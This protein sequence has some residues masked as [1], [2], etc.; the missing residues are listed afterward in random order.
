MWTQSNALQTGQKFQQTT[1]WN[2]FLVFP[3]KGFGISCKLSLMEPICMK[4]QT[5][6]LGKNKKTII[7]LSSAEF[8]RTLQT[9]DVVVTVQTENTWATSQCSPRSNC[10][11]EHFHLG[12]HCLLI[13]SSRNRALWWFFVIVLSETYLADIQWNHHRPSLSTHD[14]WV[15]VQNRINIGYIFWTD[16]TGRPSDSSQRPFFIWQGIFYLSSKSIS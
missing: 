16:C 9:L 12:L 5:Y 8:A 1:F 6:Y 11:Y 2:I 10:S 14:L 13:Y 7:N 15:F 4:C 3:E